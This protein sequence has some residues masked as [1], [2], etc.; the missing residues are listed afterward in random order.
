M[1]QKKS[2]QPALKTL[3]DVNDVLYKIATLQN[4]VDKKTAKM[5]NELLDVKK[6]YEPE[7]TEMQNTIII[8]ESQLNEFCKA[9][10]KEFSVTRSKELTYGRIGFRTGKN[11]LKLLSKKFTWEF[12]KEKFLNMF[13]SRYVETKFQLDK[14]KIIKD[15]EK[16]I[17]TTE[18]LALAGCKLVKGESSYYE[19]NWDEIKVQE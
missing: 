2:K 7:I 16:G 1:K 14:D 15:S 3:E 10:K 13:S 12:V 9:N 8:C 18:Q 19:I 6:K 4:T 11:S 5:N 17:I